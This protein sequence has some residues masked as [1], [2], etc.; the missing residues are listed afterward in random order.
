MCRSRF[1]LES[2]NFNSKNIFLDPPPRQRRAGKSEDDKEKEGGNMLEVKI[3]NIIPV[4]EAR[5][6]LN[7]LIENVEDSD[8]MIVMT[9][10]GKPTAILVGVHHMEKLTGED[11]KEVFGV[12]P[13]STGVEPDISQI[14]EDQI[15]AAPAAETVNPSSFE[16]PQPAS[17]IAPNGQVSVDPVQT[18]S[19]DMPEN[20]MFSDLAVSDEK[21]P[22][23]T[24]LPDFTPNPITDDVNASS[25]DSTPIDWNTNAT[26]VN[27]Q[28]TAQASM[29]AAPIDSFDQNPQQDH[30]MPEAGMAENFFADLPPVDSGDIKDEENT[31]PVNQGTQMPVQ[32]PASPIN[33]TATPAQSNIQSP[34]PFPQPTINQAPQPQPMN[35]QQLG[36]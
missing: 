34:T 12:V 3:E 36:Q 4:T 10:N 33:S 17:S 6:K 15:Q 27:S 35:N 18:N 14:A 31:V 9:K 16:M 24:P 26:P 29:P 28:P 32:Q 23:V 5:D 2:R 22:S 20:N 13:P 19:F 30:D 7:Q 21:N 25:Q 8:E 11:H 1:D